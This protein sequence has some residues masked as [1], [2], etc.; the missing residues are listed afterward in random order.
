[1]STPD[2]I[3]VFPGRTAWTPT[4]E[5]A[6]IGE[7]GLFRPGNR[8][9]PIR[10]SVTFTWDKPEAERL[11][12]SWGHYYDDVQIGGPAYGDPGAEFEPGLF[13]REGVTI[14]SRGCPKRCGWCYVPKREGGLREYEI[15]PG[16]CVQDNNL[17]ACSEGHIR[18]VF[19][20]LREQPHAAVFNGGLDKHYIKPWHR[21]LFDSI[22]VGELWWACDQLKD[23]VA[24]EKVIDL[25]AGMP[26]A[27]MRCYTMIG[28]DGETLLEAERRL[29][30]V[31]AM[32]FL[33]FCQ[34]YRDDVKMPAHYPREWRALA[35]KW[36]RPAAYR[37]K[38]APREPMPLLDTAPLS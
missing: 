27:K 25:C 14:T 28:Y 22:R 38:P 10:I 18:A 21:D 1:M 12:L 37:S 16:W 13:M 7:P 6:F 11:R 26:Q 34:L 4:D 30:T 23:I 29:E 17:L 5:H 19:D 33:P 31:Y 8:S 2:I 35:R 3:R 32:G 20:M 9:T 15:K 36:S 24:L